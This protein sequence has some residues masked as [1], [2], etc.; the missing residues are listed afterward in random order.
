[1]K[2]RG[3]T[4]MKIISYVKVLNILLKSKDIKKYKK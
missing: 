3:K 4:K 1:M 2:E